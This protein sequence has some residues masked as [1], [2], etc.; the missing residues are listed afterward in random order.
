MMGEVP[1]GL[2]AATH[3]MSSTVAAEAS[4]AAVA[5]VGALGRPVAIDAEAADAGEL[6]TA[7]VATTVKV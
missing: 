3:V 2:V 1:S 5:P 7:V 4:A 6:P